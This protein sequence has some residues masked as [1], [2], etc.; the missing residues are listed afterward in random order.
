MHCPGAG[1]SWALKGVR[2]TRLSS[3]LLQRFADRRTFC[4][5]QTAFFGGAGAGVA[6]E[7]VVFQRSA[8]AF[9]AFALRILRHRLDGGSAELGGDVAFLG[10]VSYDGVLLGNV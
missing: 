3:R 6:L 8:G 1:V 2:I 5:D 4:A 10:F 9:R 7:E